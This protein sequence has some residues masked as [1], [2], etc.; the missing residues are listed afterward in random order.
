MMKLGIRKKIDPYGILLA[1]F[2]IQFSFIWIFKRTIFESNMVQYFFFVF[3]VAMF[4]WL[5][6]LNNKA[7]RMEKPVRIWM[8]FMLFTLMMSVFSLSTEIIVYYV[9]CVVIMILS[10]KKHIIKN[11]PMW[12]LIFLGIYSVVGILVQMLLPAYYAIFIEP[13]FT[14]QNSES[15]ILIW[16]ESGYGFAGFAYQLD[17]TSNFLLLAEAAWIYYYKPNI[18]KI[19][20]W[21]VLIALVIFVFLTGKRFASI[22]S[23]VIPIGIMFISQKNAGRTI[24]NLFLVF[25]VFSVGIFYFVENARDYQDSKVLGR[26][27]RSV[28]DYKRGDDIESGRKELREAAWNMWL[29]NPILGV[30]LSQKSKKG[31]VLEIGCHNSYLQTLCDY[32]I[33][34]FLL[35][36]PPLVFCVFFTIRMIKNCLRSPELKGWLEFSLFIQIY[37]LLSGWAGNPSTDHHRYSMYYIAIAILADA[38]CRL[39]ML[40]RESLPNNRNSFEL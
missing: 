21:S 3:F 37:F 5:Y 10:A 2:I 18:G 11:F 1:I 7:V 16:Q 9:S 40:R 19:F 36:F 26:A 17:I 38:T 15:S 20:Y 22:C 34:G 27:A 6:L 30:G 33:V 12:I 8:P 39:R 29:R 4:S 23:I 14:T 31:T 24:A 13:L 28:M 32:G 25:I 35:W